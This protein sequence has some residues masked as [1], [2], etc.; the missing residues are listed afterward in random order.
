MEL[1]GCKLHQKHKCRTSVRI[2]IIEQMYDII[3][4]LSKK[5]FPS[6]GASFLLLC[7]I[8]AD[9]D[10]SQKWWKYP[11]FL[12]SFFACV[13]FLMWGPCVYPTPEE[14]G[15]QGLLRR[16]FLLESVFL[17]H[18]TICVTCNT[19]RDTWCLLT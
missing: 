19:A 18:K 8:L 5:F 17:S 11:R 6:G 16:F 2:I 13:P 12:G 1:S 10:P 9:L 4:I 15:T 3:N 7:P 14:R